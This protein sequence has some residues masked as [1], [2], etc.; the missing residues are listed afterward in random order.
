MSEL[1]ITRAELFALAAAH[2]FESLVNISYEDGEFGEDLTSEYHKITAALRDKGWL[3]G[4]QCSRYNF[5]KMRIVMNRRDADEVPYSKRAFDLVGHLTHLASRTLVRAQASTD[6][7][8]HRR[9]VSAHIEQ[10]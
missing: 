7:R 8:C 2:G 1:E 6:Q 9:A 5:R 4:C 10:M 3:E